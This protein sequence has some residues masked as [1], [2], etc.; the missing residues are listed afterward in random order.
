MLPML[1]KPQINPSILHKGG[2]LEAPDEAMTNEITKKRQ[3][4]VN[5]VEDDSVYVCT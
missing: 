5:T 4:Y 3:V 1:D 2:F